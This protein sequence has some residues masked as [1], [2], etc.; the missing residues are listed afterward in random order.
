M[1]CFMFAVHISR[2]LRDQMRLLAVLLSQVIAFD[3]LSA[4]TVQ[5]L[6]LDSLVQQSWAIAQVTVGNVESFWTGTPGTSPIATRVTFNIGKVY[7]G[8]VPAS[9]D[10]NFLG[11][12]I[13]SRKMWIPGIPQF[14][15]GQRLIVFLA[16]PQERRVSGTI[17]LD[18]GVLRILSD[19]QTGTDRIY[20]WWGQGVSPRTNFKERAVASTDAT[21]AAGNVETLADFESQLS[22]SMAKI[23]NQ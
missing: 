9:V 14:Q 12:T 16:N 17:G 22:Q 23:S 2:S 19:P 8:S 15:S 1:D 4:T 21:G 20:R 11:G 3:H 5:S 7:K 13:G 10:T 6:D 18:Q